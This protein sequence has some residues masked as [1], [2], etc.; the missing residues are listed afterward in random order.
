MHFFNPVPVMPLV[1]VVQGRETSEQAVATA[2]AWSL[3]MRKTPIV[4][5]DVPGFLVNRLL[6]PYTN[7]FV[8]LVSEGVDFEQIDRAMEDFGWPMG[9]AYLSDVVGMDTA[10]HVGDVI[11]AGYPDRM[12]PAQRNAPKL[13][14][15]HGRLG[16]KGGAG[17]YRYERDAESGRLRKLSDPAAHALLAPWRNGEAAVLT[18]EAIV[19]RIMLPVLLEAVRALHDGTVG[20]AAELD[21]AMLLGVGW[22]AYLGGPLTLIDWL[23]AAEVMARCDRLASSGP[24]YAVPAALRE[25]AASRSRF[26]E[27]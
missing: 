22:P 9:P 27:L 5:K 6:G 20:T 23:G 11:A 15:Q 14:V 16:Q 8:R 10:A 7:A 2:V 4:V 18:Q 26:Y 1:E 21:M 24:E 17:F 25:M 3:A 12:R 13:M 19:D